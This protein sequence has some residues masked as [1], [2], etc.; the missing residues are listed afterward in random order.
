M[1]KIAN[2]IVLDID[3][4][5]SNTIVIAATDET[6]LQQLSVSPTRKREP[7]NAENLD[8]ALKDYFKPKDPKRIRKPTMKLP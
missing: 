8:D 3:V 1:S 2:T 4:E 5:D 7:S 6:S